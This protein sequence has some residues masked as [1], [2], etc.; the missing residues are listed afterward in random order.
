VLR[1]QGLA[2]QLVAAGVAYAR[3]RGLQIRASCSYVADWLAR[4]S[5]RS[6]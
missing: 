2:A 3:E 5:R 4:E 1:G 6:S